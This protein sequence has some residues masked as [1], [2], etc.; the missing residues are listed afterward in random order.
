MK[1]SVIIV[2]YNGFAHTKNAIDSVH[3]CSPA[4]ELIVVDNRS[5]DGSAK[6]LAAE[7]P[8]IQ[9]VVSDENRGFAAGCN[10]G[11]RVATG[12][13]LFFL[14]NDAVL[15]EDTPAILASVLETNP[16]VCACGPKLK[17]PDGQFEI[18]FGNDPSLAGEW[19]MRRMHR[20]LRDDRGEYSK[21]L[22]RRYDANRKVDWITGAALMV[23]REGFREAGG[24]D[25][26]F[27]MYFEDA[28]L[29]RRMR[30]MN[31]GILYVP[32][33]PVLHV[34]GGSTDQ[35]VRRV[36]S[37]YR[38]SQIRYYRKHRSILS[39]YVLRVYLGLRP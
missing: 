32:S 22:E 33:T 34:R 14:N 20:R 36:R 29:C 10:A 30:E 39:Q 1:V 35:N 4:S 25:E 19:R 27:F 5:A 38:E 31:Y 21:I 11:E 16:G 3:R 37:A 15:V 6:L 26:R 28:D 2:N 9:L 7:F 24:F 17:S 8:G 13:Y 23:R 18:S 12:N